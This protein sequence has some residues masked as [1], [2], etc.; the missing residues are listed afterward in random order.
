VICDRFIDSSRAYQGG[1]NGLSD[2]DVSPCTPSAAKACCPI[3]R[4]C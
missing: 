1:G 4:S 2:A 3:A